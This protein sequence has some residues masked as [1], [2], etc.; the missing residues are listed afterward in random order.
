MKVANI[1]LHID[2]VYS[3]VPNIYMYCMSQL[4]KPD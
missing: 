3:I 4:L 2:V 1:N